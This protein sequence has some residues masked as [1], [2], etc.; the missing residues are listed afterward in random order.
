M[1]GSP[2][3]Q[4]ITGADFEAHIGDYNS[5]N[6]LSLFTPTGIIP[7]FSPDALVMIADFR[8]L[9]NLGVIDQ[10]LVFESDTFVPFFQ[11]RWNE[12]NN[13]ID[14]D[15]AG[16][17][18][19]VSQGYEV[20]VTIPSAYIKLVYDGTTVF[21]Y[22]END[23]LLFSGVV[24]PDSPLPIILRCIAGQ[25]ASGSVTGSATI[26]LDIYQPL[27]TPSPLSDVATNIINSVSSVLG[28]IA[29]AIA[30]NAGVIGSI[31]VVGAVA[32][33]IM[34]F[35]QK[36]FKGLGGWFKGLF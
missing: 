10:F 4:V 25:S 8:S 12:S 5:G 17:V 9:H 2:Y 34:S 11:I 29:T 22:D 20:G 35:G 24:G 33:G 15:V 14:F 26:S 1:T 18:N 6:P 32:I 19:E 28:S 36:I 16:S 23:T 3:S 13:I 7:A 31:I 27:P 21:A 30:A